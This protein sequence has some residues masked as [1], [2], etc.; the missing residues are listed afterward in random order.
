MLGMVSM[1]AIVSLVCND[2]VVMM[3]DW[4]RHSLNDSYLSDDSCLYKD[5]RVAYSIQNGHEID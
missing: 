1:S 3:V 4:D 5:C 2:L